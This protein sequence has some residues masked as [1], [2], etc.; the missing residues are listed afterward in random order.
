VDK[1]FE[2]VPDLKGSYYMIKE[3]QPLSRNIKTEKIDPTF[4]L[5]PYGNNNIVS[6]DAGH[7]NTKIL[8]TVSD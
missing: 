4:R 7:S 3:E 2:K 8:N 6:F 5:N 1:I